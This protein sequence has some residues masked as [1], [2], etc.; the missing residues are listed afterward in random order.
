MHTRRRR[1]SQH[2]DGRQS[3]RRCTRVYSLAGVAS[4]NPISQRNA[5]GAHLARSRIDAVCTLL[6]MFDALMPAECSVASL[7]RPAKIDLE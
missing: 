3:H 4:P 5:I 6:A 1:N 2:F 7:H